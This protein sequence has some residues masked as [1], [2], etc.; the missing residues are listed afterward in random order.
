M[1]SNTCVMLLMVDIH[2][3]VFQQLGIS[4]AD[5]NW[6]SFAMSFQGHYCKL[7]N[8]LNLVVLS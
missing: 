3:F 6:K 2:I 4:R 8:V 7:V 1:Q 5:E